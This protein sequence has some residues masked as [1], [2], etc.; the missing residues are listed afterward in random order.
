M[1]SP[2][3]RYLWA[4]ARSQVRQEP[5]GYISGFLLDKKG[6]IVKRMF[7]V[8]TGTAATSSNAITTA[9]WSDEYA[10]LA[11]TPGGYVQIWKLD[12]RKETDAGIE[13]GSAKMVSSIDL[14]NGSCCANAVWYS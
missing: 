9:P 13:Y 1:L 14:G 5:T 10:A 12:G 6:A 2:N 4:T 3:N 8:P 7:M 11:D